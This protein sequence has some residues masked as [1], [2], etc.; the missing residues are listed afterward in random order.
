MLYGGVSNGEPNFKCLTL[1]SA[2]VLVT[3]HINVF[4]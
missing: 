3:V 2:E 1:S 4:I